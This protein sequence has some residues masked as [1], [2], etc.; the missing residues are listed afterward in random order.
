MSNPTS[1]AHS[2]P[3]QQPPMAL[4]WYPEEEENDLRRFAEAA[5]Q[6]A[7]TRVRCR[8]CKSVLY[9]LQLIE[10]VTV[11]YRMRWFECRACHSRQSPSG[12]RERHPQYFPPHT[13][14]HSLQARLC[15]PTPPE[16]DLDTKTEPA[17]DAHTLPPL[18]NTTV[19][20]TKTAT[21]NINQLVL[22]L[23]KQLHAEYELKSATHLT[24]IVTLTKELEAVKKTCEVLARCAD[25]YK[26]EFESL[27]EKDS[28]L[29]ADLKKKNAALY[30]EVT[31]LRRVR[32]HLKDLV[33]KT[34]EL[35]KG[36]FMPVRM[37]SM[38]W[39]NG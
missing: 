9:T 20:A 19:A 13:S 24:T 23:S 25:Q 17:A 36:R 10:D 4:P 2:T 30:K 34:A 6:R 38:G 22:D 12:I 27:K 11:E 1:E 15:G 28:A 18:A 35:S 21:T 31:C 16:S 5:V 8:D 33:G 39:A 7:D 29:V 26:A 14:H 32:R 3:F 37:G